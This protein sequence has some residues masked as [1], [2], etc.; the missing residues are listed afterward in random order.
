LLNERLTAVQLNQEEQHVQNDQSPGYNRNS[1][2]GRVIIANWKHVVG[3]PFENGWI[4]WAS[5]NSSTNSYRRETNDFEEQR[6][7][8]CIR[9]LRVAVE[10]I[11][12]CSVLFGAA[13]SGIEQH[14]EIL[15]GNTSTPKTLQSS[16]HP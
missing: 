6:A 12:N 3:P 14:P 7:A 13:T 5:C 8:D 11:E 2:S 15:V 10:V 16:D 9:T 1:P 4:E